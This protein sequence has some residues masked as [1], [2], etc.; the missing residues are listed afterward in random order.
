[1]AAS[2]N[3]P[4]EK[5]RCESCMALTEDSWG[6][7]CKIIQCLRKK[8]MDF[9]YTC[10]EYASRS[11]DKFEEL[12]RGYLTDE[13]VDIRANLERI[14]KVG[15]GEWLL[16]WEMKYK[17]PSCGKPLSLASRMKRCYHCGAD[18]SGQPNI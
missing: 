14:K 10:P 15:A 6:F 17:C 4:P 5:V 8:G 13:G 11:C 9:C 2:L 7:D 18:L 3:C 1:V 16:E 12:A